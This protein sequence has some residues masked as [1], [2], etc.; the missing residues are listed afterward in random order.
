MVALKKLTLAL[1]VVIFLSVVP[2][3]VQLSEAPRIVHEFDNFIV[4]EIS[5]DI[6]DNRRVG[7]RAIAHTLYQKYEDVFDVIVMLFNVSAEKYQWHD[8]GYGWNRIVRNSVSGDAVKDLDIGRRFG[9]G[10]TLKGIIGLTRK[11]Y[12]MEGPMLHEFMHLWVWTIEVIP[13][14]KKFHWGFSSV[15]GQLGGFDESTLVYEGD[16]VYR[17]QHK[18]L[19]GE[20]IYSPL[21]LYLAGWIEAAE[22]PPIL[23]AENATWNTTSSIEDHFETFIASGFDTITIDDIIKKIGVRDPGVEQS[24]KHFRVATILLVNNEFPFVQED[25]D[26]VES[27]LKLFSSKKAVSGRKGRVSTIRPSFWEATGGRA[28][29]ST[30]MNNA[31]KSNTNSGFSQN[32]K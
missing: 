25:L 20:R 12:I 11:E 16:N 13:T 30:D 6:L 32:L 29:V 19:A 3:C 23:V 4:V 9:S 31:L 22:V 14:L 2:S 8:V 7:F 26:L 27:Q 24:Q 21:E 28:S 17:E 15:N 5:R 18:V 10:H 1:I